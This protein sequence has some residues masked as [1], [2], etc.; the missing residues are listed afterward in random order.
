[1]VSGGR[2]GRPGTVPRQTFAWVSEAC[3]T[4]IA[5][6]HRHR[7]A[8]TPRAATF[9]RSCGL[10]LKTESHKP[11]DLVCAGPPGPFGG[12]KTMKRCMWTLAALPG[13]VLVCTNAAASPTLSH[14]EV[15][16][17]VHQDTFASLR[18][19][20]PDPARYRAW[21]EHAEHTIPL[22]FT[23]AGQVDGALQDYRGPIGLLAP[24]FQSGVDGVGNGF[25]GPNGTF[26]VQY[27]PPDTVGAAGATQYVQVV[28]VGFA[29]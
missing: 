15:I 21:H 19:V 3:C 1:M 4:R 28:N 27:A 9:Y 6:F 24:T 16:H 7:P 26:T 14:A 29:V 22:P 20:V 11:I 23:P 13:L 10:G 5:P 8:R 2:T 12:V 17:A 18:D 25:S